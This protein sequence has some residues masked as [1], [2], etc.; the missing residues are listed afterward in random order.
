MNTECAVLAGGCFWGMQDL[1]R[2]VSSGLAGSCRVAGRR[3][4]SWLDLIRR[5]IAGSTARTRLRSA[6]ETPLF[7]SA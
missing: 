7:R 3:D 5:V 2:T 6:P 1:F 4:Q